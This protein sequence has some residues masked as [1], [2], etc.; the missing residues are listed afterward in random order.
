MA[1]SLYSRSSELQRTKEALKRE[2]SAAKEATETLI[3]T[4]MSAG[5]AF[6]LSYLRAAYPQSVGKG[7]FGM[8]VDLLAG[9]VGVG[10]GATG[11]VKDKTMSAYLEALGVGA[12]AAY[13]ARKGS[14]MGSK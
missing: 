12:L 8:D 1:I 10:A 14:E 7:V 13:A 5:S 4:A 6:G 2:R 3:E 9:L 11:L